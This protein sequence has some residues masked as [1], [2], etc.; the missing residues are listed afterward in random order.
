MKS[1][2]RL[3]VICNALD[4]GTRLERGI[5]TD[6]PAASRKVF[7]L[8][9]LLRAQAVRTWVISLGRGGQDGSGRFFAFK[10]KRVAGCPV[11]Y[12]PFKHS[13]FSSL[14]LTLFG[15]LFPLWRLTRMPG[16]NA[17]MFYNRMP[18]Y[19]MALIFAKLSR[20]PAFLDIE[21]G[22]V[23]A[24][25]NQLKK[26]VVGW[27][28]GIYAWACSAGT[29]LA[30]SALRSDT[31]DGHTLCYY[32]TVESRPTAKDWKTPT[33]HVLLGGTISRQTGADALLNCIDTLARERPAWARKLVVE[34]TGK[35]D[36]IEEFQSLA[37]RPCG[38]GGLVVHGRATDA[39]YKEI[40]ERCHVGLAL[41]PAT[42]PLADTTFPSKVVELVGAGL[43]LV[44]TDISD[45]RLLF[46]SSAMY[47]RAEESQSLYE[48][49][50]LITAWPDRAEASAQEASA[51]A[52]KNFDPN[53]VGKRLV[54]F[55]FDG[56]VV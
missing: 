4:D 34:I 27:L 49:L 24:G 38:L 50:R 6:S 3:L 11:V 25:Q 41:K 45:V 21:D 18:A 35:G 17:I 23:L 55:F 9:R 26:W 52:H 36:L 5:T 54:R 8:C 43:L 10:V 12:L 15:V 33:I 1:K 31:K 37:E 42:G 53:M 2:T 32:G 47:V 56:L 48:A 14:L 20:L 19:V 13:G 22:E 40:L 30:C 7:M 44:S 46:G 28:K 16:S 39:A 29:L 51:L